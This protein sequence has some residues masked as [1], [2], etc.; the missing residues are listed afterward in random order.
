M[1]TYLLQKSLLDFAG[2]SYLVHTVCPGKIT[3]KYLLD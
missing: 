1:A 2:L 3:Q